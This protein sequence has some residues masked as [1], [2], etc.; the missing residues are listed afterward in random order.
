[1][2]TSL[3]FYAE[4]RRDNNQVKKKYVVCWLGCVCS[5]CSAHSQTTYNKYTMPMEWR[6]G[7]RTFMAEPTWFAKLRSLSKW[8]SRFVIRVSWSASF[9]D[10]SWIKLTNCSMVM[11]GCLLCFVVWLMSCVF[12]FAFFSSS[13]DFLGFHSSDAKFHSSVFSAR[14]IVPLL[15]FLLRHFGRLKLQWVCECHHWIH[16]RKLRSFGKRRRE[17]Q[18]TSS[19]PRLLIQQNKAKQTNNNNNTNQTSTLTITT[20]TT[21]TNTCLT[22]RRED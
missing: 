15:D 3:L 19:S 7:L 18:H 9:L 14:T 17:Q 5:T 1:M 6:F 11:L 2:D 13:K 21:Y 20:K 8:F 12:L 16:T 4:E 22:K 10:W